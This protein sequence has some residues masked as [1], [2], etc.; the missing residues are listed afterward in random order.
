MVRPGGMTAQL[1]R[2]HVKIAVRGWKDEGS[3]KRHAM[4]E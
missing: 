2:L 1:G 3:S 4:S